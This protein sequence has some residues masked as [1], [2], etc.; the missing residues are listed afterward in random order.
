MS[1]EIIREVRRIRHRIS[2]ECDH[3]VH[4][5]VAYYRAFQDELKRSGEYRFYNPKG[6]DGVR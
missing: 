2:S 6:A 5:V 3:D 1:D 4:K